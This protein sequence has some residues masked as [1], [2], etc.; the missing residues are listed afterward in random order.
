MFTARADESL[1]IV[2]APEDPRWNGHAARDSVLSYVA[3]LLRNKEGAALGTLCHFDF[4]SRQPPAGTI[5]LLNAVREPVERHLWAR[6][7]VV[8]A[9]TKFA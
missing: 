7:I 2:D 3:V 1:V 5:E 4:C 8:D 9:S 6:G